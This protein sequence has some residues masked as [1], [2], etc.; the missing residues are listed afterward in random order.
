MAEIETGDVRF[1]ERLYAHYAQS[2]VRQQTLVDE[3]SAYQ[4]IEIFDTEQNGRVLALDG[5][6][7]MTTRDEAAYAEM[8][9]H[10]PIL[11]HGA[12]ERVLIVG[13][14][15][16]SIAEECLKH[17]RVKGVDMAE[18]DGRVVELCRQHFPDVNARAFADPRLSVHIT[19]AA[20]FLARPEAAGRYD[21][22]ISD[23]PDPVGPAGVLFE[24]GFY[25]S[26]ARAL[27]ARGIAVFQTGVPF[28]QPSELRRDIEALARVFRHTG[29]YLA[30]VPTYIGG[31]MA[32]TYASNGHALGNETDLTAAAQRF[33]DTAL[34]TDHYTP[35]LHRAAFALPRWIE[36]LAR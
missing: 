4:H 21:L 33:A 1:Q 25:A 5:I 8:L 19:D 2:F 26:I 34:A 15:D 17:A 11:E 10:V 24:G 12:V 30:V 18:I 7:Q 35:A 3:R 14:G 20:L 29:V 28:Y 13:G 9:T 22:I 6:V 32:L 36:R 16:G 27:T 23:R 31:Y